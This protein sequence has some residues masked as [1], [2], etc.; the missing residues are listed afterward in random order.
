MKKKIA[1][2]AAA[3]AVLAIVSLSVAFGI[4]K[5]RA[6]VLKTKYDT[7]MTNQNA[8]ISNLNSAENQV[9]V[10]K[11]TIDDLRHIN[12]SIT[13]ECLAL[14][15]SLRIK[16]RDLKQMQYLYSHYTHTD[17]VIFKDTLYLDPDL[18]LDT[19]VGDEWVSTRIEMIWPS[20]ISVTPD[21]R[22]EK[23]IL[24]YLKKE[25]VEAPKPTWIGRLFQKKHK[26]ANVVID[27]K[28]PYIS[29]QLNEFIEIT[30]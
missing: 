14:K 17:T 5:H 8:Y 24:V 23:K 18:C 26:V 2:C 28:N 16:D 25:T 4:V 10:Y 1:I 30:E 6:D 27:E 20:Y 12:D 11:L 13:N 22:S 9:H 15:K 3:I 19:V 7:A 21:V 29:D